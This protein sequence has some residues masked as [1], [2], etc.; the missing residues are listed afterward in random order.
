[1]NWYVGNANNIIFGYTVN[2]DTTIMIFSITCVWW[3]GFLNQPGFHFE[4]CL[5]LAIE[6]FND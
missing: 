2:A 4:T 1:V 5:Y 6:L 3:R